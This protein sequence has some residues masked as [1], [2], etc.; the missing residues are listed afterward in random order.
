M[1][2]SGTVW[3]LWGLSDM[4]QSGMIYRVSVEWGG[5]RVSVGLGS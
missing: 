3:R 1:W 2:P 4:E 5:D